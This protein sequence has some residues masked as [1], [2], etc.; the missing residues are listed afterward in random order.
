MLSTLSSYQQYITAYLIRALVNH[1]EG[2]KMQR[3]KRAIKATTQV[4]VN[5]L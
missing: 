1:I 5:E 3:E 2:V 4:Q